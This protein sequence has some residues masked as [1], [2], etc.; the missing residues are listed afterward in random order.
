[1]ELK[2]T[3]PKKTIIINNEK[4]DYSNRYKGDSNEPSNFQER[5]SV[6]FCSACNESPCMCSDRERSSSIYDF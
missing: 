3:L 1:M 6:P 5:E 2:Y 4:F